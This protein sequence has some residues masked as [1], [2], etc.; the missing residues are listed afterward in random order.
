MQGQ[1]LHETG[2]IWYS[3]DNRVGAQ[4]LPEIEKEVLGNVKQSK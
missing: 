4:C 3:I 1:N 2:K